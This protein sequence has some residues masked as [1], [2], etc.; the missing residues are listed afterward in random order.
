MIS[1]R[2]R[3]ALRIMADMAE[4]DGGEPVSIREIAERQDISAKYMEQIVSALVRAGLV[5]SVRGAQ[6]GYHLAMRPAEI[7]AGMILRATEGDLAP[8]QCLSPGGAA[9]EY[10]GTCPSRNV[11]RRLYGAINGVIDGITLEEMIRESETDN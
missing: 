1:S 7:T 10:A 9:C 3:Y 2:G 4:H 11:F 5:R 8:S 6:G